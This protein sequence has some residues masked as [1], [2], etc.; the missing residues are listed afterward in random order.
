MKTAKYIAMLLTFVV[1]MWGGNTLYKL[2]SKEPEAE[3]AANSMLGK[4]MPDFS[5]PDL[6]NQAHNIHEWDGN[7]I[8]LN[9]WATWC[10][11]CLKET[12]MFVELQ[13]KYGAKGLQFI[14]VAIDNADQVRDFVNT[15]GINYPT[16]IAGAPDIKIT[17]QYG[18]H[19]DALPYT[20][21]IDRQGRI[22]HIQR[23]ELKR[24][25][26]EKN[27]LALL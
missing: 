17:R 19:F 23:G 3:L 15:Y 20:V 9:F 2:I 4:P 7:V 6:N 13:N 1:G 26:A 25:A 24:P 11:P 14:G 21:I 16:L 10:T 8:V 18:N 5:L 22:S 27:I 12:P